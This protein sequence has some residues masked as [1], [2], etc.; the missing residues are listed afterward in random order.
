MACIAEGQTNY[1]MGL[2]VG[3]MGEEDPGGN[4]VCQIAF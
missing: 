3:V 1:K 2:V 4:V